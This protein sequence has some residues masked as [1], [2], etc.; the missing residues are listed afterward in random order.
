MNIDMNVHVGRDTH[1]CPEDMS[2]RE[3]AE[4]SPLSVSGCLCPV[5]F[6]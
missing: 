5:F 6:D 2:H 1:T 4:V 3:E